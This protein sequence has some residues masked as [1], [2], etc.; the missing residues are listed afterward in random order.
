MS[1]TTVVLSIWQSRTNDVILDSGRPPKWLTNT[2]RLKPDLV[3]NLWN[4]VK[5]NG[6]KMLERQE[7]ACTIRIQWEQNK[8]QRRSKDSWNRKLWQETYG[9]ASAMFRYRWET[10][11]R[12]VRY[13]LSSQFQSDVYGAEIFTPFLRASQARLSVSIVFFTGIWKCLSE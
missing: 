13:G 3:E 1:Q 5:S 11:K 2:R 6:V 4:Q 9:A 8:F 10:Y 7:K 12:E